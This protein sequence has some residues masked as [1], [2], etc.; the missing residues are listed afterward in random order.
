IGLRRFANSRHHLEWARARGVHLTTVE[1]V[2]ALGAA[3]AAARALAAV[4]ECDAL[5][6]S[7]D[8]DAADAAVAPGVSAAGVGGLSA[9]EMI[10]LVRALAADPRL[11]AA[12]L[13]ELSPPYDEGGRTAKLGARL[14]LELLNG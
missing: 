12:D 7:V 10:A 5:Y 2:E 4:G 1:E 14:L 9:R 11:L 13:M 6:L 3:G 8:L